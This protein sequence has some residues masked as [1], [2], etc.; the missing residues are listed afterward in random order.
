LLNEKGAEFRYREYTQEPLSAAEI[1]E[2]L[3]KLGVGP[4]AV[5]RKRDA[6]YKAAGLTGDESDEALIAHMAEHPTLLQRPIG[7]LGEEAALGR[8]VENLL[9]LLD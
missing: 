9:A 2:V 4:K 1:R 8:P 3:G 6:A 7:V 5:L